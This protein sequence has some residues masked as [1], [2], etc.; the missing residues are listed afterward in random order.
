M[1]LD[2]V[3]VIGMG[4]SMVEPLDKSGLLSP[5]NFDIGLKGNTMN[6]GLRTR[7]VSDVIDSFELGST[8]SSSASINQ[9]SPIFRYDRTYSSQS[10]SSS[11]GVSKS[12]VPTPDR[13][14]R[15][16]TSSS[17]P[18]EHPIGMERA[19]FL[20]GETPAASDETDA[21]PRGKEDLEDVPAES[22]EEC[23]EKK[24]ELIEARMTAEPGDE[25]YPMGSPHRRRGIAAI[26][27][28]DKFSSEPERKGSA[29]DVQALH[30]TLSSLGFEVAIH[31]NLTRGK[32]A[33][34]LDKLVNA[35]LDDC[36]CFCLAVLTHGEAPEL[37][38]AKD[39]VYRQNELW[40]P[41]TGQ[42]C[43][44]LAGKPK[45]FLIQACRGE[46]LDTGV[47]LVKY[48]NTSQTDS[49]SV[50]WS[51][52]IP[53][54]ADFL[55]A[56]SSVEGFFSWRNPEDGTWWIQTLCQELESRGSTTDLLRILTIVNRRVALEF[57]SY[58]LNRPDLSGCKEI[59]SFTSTLTRDLYFR[60]TSYQ[61]QDEPSS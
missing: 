27:N 12:S 47:R 2:S 6:H 7:R 42:S 26:F 1:P 49:G 37:L 22:N 31:P 34:E 40:M 46:G 39:G 9:Y 19:Q 17:D 45:I 48:S 10:S 8:P 24:N 3:P 20:Y 53:S 28:N 56:H 38:H 15:E 25:E 43:P 33:E 18:V 36:E 35:D 29:A 57:E 21:K 23:D 5:V 16:S 13:P 11:Q 51:Y 55:I 60:P 59:P 58:V 41:F 54:W 52:V 61:V 4:G 50:K 14:R 44:K 32:I 30:R